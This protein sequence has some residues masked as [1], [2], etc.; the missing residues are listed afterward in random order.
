MTSTVSRANYGIAYKERFDE[1]K[2]LNEDKYWDE[3]EGCFMA[4]HQMQWYLNRV[5]SAS[6]LQHAPL[7]DPYLAG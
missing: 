1:N 2:H 6:T 5:S 3:I 7:S 4:K